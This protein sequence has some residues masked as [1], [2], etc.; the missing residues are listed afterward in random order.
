MKTLF[1]LLCMVLPLYAVASKYTPA[2][3]EKATEPITAG[4][5]SA[6][7]NSVTAPAYKDIK[8][9]AITH[10]YLLVVGSF[11][12]ELNATNMV[13]QMKHKGEGYPYVAI[14]PEGK[15]RVVYQSSDNDAELREILVSIK[16]EYPSAWILKL[17]D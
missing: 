13:N 5:S 6:K 14:S 3:Y 10:K 1:A 9:A 4:T 7:Q 17:G 2:M 8:G 16:S 11:K 15:H 12:D